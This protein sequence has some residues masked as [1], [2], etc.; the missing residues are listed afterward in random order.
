MPPIRPDFLSDIKARTVVNQQ[1]S[2]DA[3]VVKI[4]AAADAGESSIQV[5]TISAYAEAQLAL[6][7][8]RANSLMAV[9]NMGIKISW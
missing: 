9:Q 1:K 4:E 5:D 6:V 3:I 7:G 2:L 8:I